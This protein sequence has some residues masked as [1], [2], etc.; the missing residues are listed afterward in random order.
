MYTNNNCTYIITCMARACGAPRTCQCVS[1]HRVCHAF[2]GVTRLFGLLG[3]HG[4]V[5][6][7]GRP[8]VFGDGAPSTAPAPQTDVS[9]LPGCPSPTIYRRQTTISDVPGGTAKRGRHPRSLTT[10]AAAGG[11][12][13]PQ[14]Q[15]PAT[16]WGQQ[17][18]EGWLAS[19]SGTG[20]GCCDSRARTGRNTC[21]A[22]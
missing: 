12:P 14:R 13:A 15:S 21:L 4:P 17:K 3:I 20:A 6:P 22:G 1:P 5:P 19:Q 18:D 10:T 9:G 16:A 8:N 7:T 11:C 2:V